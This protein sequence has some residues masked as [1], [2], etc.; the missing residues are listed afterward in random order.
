[1]SLYTWNLENLG[2]NLSFLFLLPY[3][4]T[5]GTLWHLQK[6][7]QYILNSPHLS[8]IP[9]TLRIVSTCLIFSIFIHV[10]MIFSPYSPSYTLSLYPLP[11]HWYQPLER[12]CF[13]FMFSI[14]EKSHFCL[15]LITL[16]GVSLWYFYVYV[17]YVPP[18]IWGSFL[19]SFLP[20]FLLPSFYIG[21]YTRALHFLG[22]CSTTW[23]TLLAVLLWLF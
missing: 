2:F 18:S 3:Y 11:S 4:C 12:T 16:Q 8:F 1:M 7:L 9:P 21:F 17:Q 6:C 23:A 22:K 20:S 13:T 5:G 19:P 14:L 15:F 10:Y